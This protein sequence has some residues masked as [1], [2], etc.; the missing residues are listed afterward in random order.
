VNLFTPS[1]ISVPP[2]STT[3]PDNQTKSNYA[4]SIV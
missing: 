3:F 2:P 4:L 1:S